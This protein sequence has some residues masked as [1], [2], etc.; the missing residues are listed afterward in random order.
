MDLNS[1]VYSVR[2]CMWE[3][4][5]AASDQALHLL[6]S[7]ARLSFWSYIKNNVEGFKVL[8]IIYLPEEPSYDAFQTMI[9]V[10]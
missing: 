4:K 2:V 7:A 5:C 8:K 10:F 6:S 9:G 3:C 1:N